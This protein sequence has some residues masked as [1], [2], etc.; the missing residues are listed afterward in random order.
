MTTSLYIAGP[1]SG[2]PEFNY[3]AFRAAAEALRAAG[4]D[5]LNPIDVDIDG[6][7]EDERTWE[8]YMRRTLAMMLSADAIATLPGWRDSRG[9]T[10]E[11]ET[12]ARIGIGEA[13]L[14]HW[15]AYPTKAMA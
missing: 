11:V 14:T 12:A 5:V 1:M 15:L 3:P 13:P 8:W 2:L 6:T 7:T 4:Y 9:A 10:I